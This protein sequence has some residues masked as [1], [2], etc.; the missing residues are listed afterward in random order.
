[1]CGLLIEAFVCIE[2]VHG[3][4]LLLADD[5]VV[6]NSISHRIVQV[7]A[8]LLLAACFIVRGRFASGIYVG[9]GNP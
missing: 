3:E 5:D 9:G 4:S 7:V 8:A 6:C 2:G 1:M